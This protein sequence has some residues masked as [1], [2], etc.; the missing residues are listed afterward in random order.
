MVDPDESATSASLRFEWTLDAGWSERSRFAAYHR[1]AAAW[2]AAKLRQPKVAG[3]RSTHLGALRD[4]LGE[5]TTLTVTRSTNLG[6]SLGAAAGSYEPEVDGFGPP[7]LRVHLAVE[8]S[9]G[10]A[11]VAVRVNFPVGDHGPPEVTLAAIH[12]R[13]RTPPLP[14]PTEVERAILALSS[15]I[16]TTPDD[17]A[18]RLQLADLW[19]A[20]GEPRGAFVRA[21]IAGDEATAQA[22]LD[23]HGRGWT[24]GLPVAVDHRVYRRGFL[25]EARLACASA[26]LH[27]VID[28]PA[29]AL[30][31]ALD[32]HLDAEA[33]EVLLT[34]APLGGLR[35]LTG[36]RGT[37][38][39]TTPLPPQVT[40]LHVRGD[41][42][43]CPAQLAALEVEVHAFSRL[44]MLSRLRRLSELALLRVVGEANPR[45]DSVT[46]LYW[47]LTRQP[48]RLVLAG[49]GVEGDEAWRLEVEGD[50][51]CFTGDKQVGRRLRA[52][53][54]D[55]ARD[56]ESPG[57]G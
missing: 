45:G 22:L 16:C 8:G 18:P 39:E 30:L 5:L 13:P 28:S 26:D 4:E 42:L 50:V 49:R 47:L 31:A 44:L 17:D 54:E 27:P 57:R 40:H 10:A 43:D 20:Q 52:L 11:D 36:V 48:R 3:E 15:A 33:E 38:A 29:W 25:C 21:Q 1:A 51:R 46:V 53:I 55:V 24:D 32:L 14:P 6:A 19:L 41:L 37:T 7:R 23:R 12:P 9:A 34:R 35:R 56:S 2:L